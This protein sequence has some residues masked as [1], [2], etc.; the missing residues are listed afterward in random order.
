MYGVTTCLA[1]PGHSIIEAGQVDMRPLQL[2]YLLWLCLNCSQEGIH[3]QPTSKVAEPNA[4]FTTPNERDR[5]KG[6][7]N[8]IKRRTESLEDFSLQCTVQHKQ[9]TRIGPPTCLLSPASDPPA[10]GI[11]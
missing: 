11:A 10:S 4:Q 3:A 7:L 2:L 9:N 5:E 6:L 1:Q 8:P